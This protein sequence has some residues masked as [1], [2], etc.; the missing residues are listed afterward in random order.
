V[1][2]L[3]KVE[4]NNLFICFIYKLV[5]SFF[6]IFNVR[7]YEFVKNQQIGNLWA[8]EFLVSLSLSGDINYLKNKINAM[9]N[10]R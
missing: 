10:K 6:L 7:T 1:S 8:R 3:I 5:V 4:R 2:Y 9:P